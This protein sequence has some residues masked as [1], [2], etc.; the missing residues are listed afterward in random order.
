MDG[1]FFKCFMKKFSVPLNLG[2]H[3]VWDK[4]QNKYRVNLLYCFCA[5]CLRKFNNPYKD[6]SA[7]FREKSRVSAN[8]V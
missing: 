8:N 4:P 7:L 5:E 6:R 3:Y 2:S 1:I